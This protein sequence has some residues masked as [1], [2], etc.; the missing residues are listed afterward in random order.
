VKQDCVI[1]FTEIE[2]GHVLTP[3]QYCSDN[4]EKILSVMTLDVSM[5][6][7]LTVYLAF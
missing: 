1:L 5:V 7:I 6:Q 3:L 2:R 4:I